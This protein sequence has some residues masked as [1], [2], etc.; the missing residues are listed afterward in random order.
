MENNVSG[1]FTFAWFALIAERN[2]FDLTNWTQVSDRCPLDYMF[3]KSGVSKLKISGI[4]MS[5][6]KH[7][8][9][10]NLKSKKISN[11][12]ELIQSDP[13]SCPQNQKGNN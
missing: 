11:D 4:Y 13:I 6:H 8:F 7:Y 2:T 1:L 12:Q 10:D 5:D 3:I 9:S